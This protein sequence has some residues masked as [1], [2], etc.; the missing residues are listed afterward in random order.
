[1]TIK[2]NTE[3]DGQIHYMKRYMTSVWECLCKHGRTGEF[4]F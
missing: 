3:E 1:M 4:N 2:K